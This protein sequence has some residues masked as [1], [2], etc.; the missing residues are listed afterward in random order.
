MDPA[1]TLDTCRELAEEILEGEDCEDQSDEAVE[2]AENFQALDEWLKKA[3]ALP[4]D[5]SR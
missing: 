5:W 4:E 1:T 3:G 2:L